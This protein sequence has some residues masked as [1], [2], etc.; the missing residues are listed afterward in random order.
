MNSYPAKLKVRNLY[1]D[2][3][4]RHPVFREYFPDYADNFVPD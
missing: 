4:A 1:K 3:I 2:V